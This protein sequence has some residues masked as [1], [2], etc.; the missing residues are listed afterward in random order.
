MSLNIPIITYFT[1]DITF[2]NVTFVINQKMKFKNLE[3]NMML[4]I[5]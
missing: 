4:T 1:Q 3:R 2:R 5:I